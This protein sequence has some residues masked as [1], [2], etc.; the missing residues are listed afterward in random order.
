M[1]GRAKGKA[2]E[3]TAAVGAKEKV[4]EKVEAWMVL[5]AVIDE[6]ES[7][8]N[9]VDLSC[10]SNLS[11]NDWFEEMDSLPDLQ[12]VSDSD[13]SEM[14]ENLLDNLDDIDSLLDL[15]SVLQL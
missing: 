5:L 8:F 7:S 14:E 4:E 2:K 10:G 12:P 9:A 3:I 15:E 6:L 1:K 13:D 11:D